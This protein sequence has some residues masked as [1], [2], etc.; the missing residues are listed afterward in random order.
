MTAM[1]LQKLVYYCQAWALVRLDR[2]LFGEAIQAW[3]AGPVVRSLFAAHRGRYSLAAGDIAGDPQALTDDERDTVDKVV[4]HYGRFDAAQLSDLT[5]S[6]RPWIEARA[7]LDPTE[8]GEN[9]IE[10]TT[11][12][13]Y[14][15]S[16]VNRGQ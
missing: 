13:D 5:H 15:T 11:M 9:V 4:K 8:R 1:K 2:P 7:G 3:A 12:A 6:E 10:P 16:L 14:Y